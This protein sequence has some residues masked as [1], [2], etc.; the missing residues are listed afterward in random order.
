MNVCKSD[1]CDRKVNAYG[2]CQLHH[3]RIKSNGSV[4][5]PEQPSAE[6]RFWSKVNKSTGTDCWEWTAGR[7]KDYGGFQRLGKS[8]YAHRYSYEIAYG[9]IPEGHFIDHMCHNTIC[10]NPAHL[11]AVTPALSGQNRQGATRLSISG[12]RGV[13][14]VKKTGR[15]RARGY[16]NR[17][18][19]GIGTYGTAEEAAEAASNWRIENMPNSLADRRLAA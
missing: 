10:V 13:S 8:L 7:R 2:Y 4:N 18:C 5:L 19:Y 1:G 14:L 3:R 17:K 11:Q 9:E 6:E 16:L 15:W 12:H